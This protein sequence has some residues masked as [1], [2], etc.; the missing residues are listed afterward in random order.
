MDCVRQAG[1][2]EMNTQTTPPIVIDVKNLFV[3]YV[4]QFQ[5][6]PAVRDLSFT[7]HEQ[8]VYGLVGESGCGKS[9]AALAC[10]RYLPD[11]TVIQ[12]EVSL[13][14]QDLITLNDQALRRLR[15]NRVAMVYQDPQSALNPAMPVIKQMEE[16]LVVHEKIPSKEANER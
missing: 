8:E 6:T 2:I 15:G 10:V 1:W 13:L 16:I 12:G 9:T 11:K 4:T 14:G 5:R 7:I 3:E